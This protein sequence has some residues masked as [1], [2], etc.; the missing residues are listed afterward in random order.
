M[1]QTLECPR[2]GQNSSCGTAEQGI[3]AS[4]SPLPQ[5]PGGTA[6]VTRGSPSARTSLGKRTK[7]T[8][9]GRGIPSSSREPFPGESL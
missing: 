8:R 7:I 1:G 4:K 6:R 5:G 2:Q 3:N 9:S